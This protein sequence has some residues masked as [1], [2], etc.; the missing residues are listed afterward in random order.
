MLKT[1]ADGIRVDE[2][3]DNCFPNLVAF[4][5]KTVF[6]IVSLSDNQPNLYHISPP[7]RRKRR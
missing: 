6:P 3:G 4:C 2:V 7:F 5:E 1:I